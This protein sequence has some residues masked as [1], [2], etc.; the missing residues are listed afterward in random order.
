MSAYQ[1]AYTVLQK[2]LPHFPVSYFSV[3]MGLAGFTIVLQK[4][5]TFLN[6]PRGASLI[7]LGCATVLFVLMLVFYGMKIWQRF[8]FVRKELRHPVKLHFF[9]TISISLLLLSVAYLPLSNE[10][11]GYF[12]MTGVVLHSALMLFTLHAWMHWDIFKP[13]HM[14]PAWFIPAV[15]N[16]L[17]PIVGVVHAPVELSWF[18]F[19]VGFYF[20]IILSTIFFLRIFFHEPLTQKLLPTLCILIAPP[21]VGLIAYVQLIGR[22][23][24]FA[25]MLYNIALAMTILLLSQGY[26]FVRLP[27]YLSWW[28]YSFP[29]AAIGI[30]SVHMYH[31]T[32]TPMYKYLFIFFSVVLA[33]C[34][35]ILVLKTVSAIKKGTICVEE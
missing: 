5:E 22:V 12:W 35:A 27:F 24:V 26:L 30:A 2:R 34:I 8:D 32:T 31:A 18:Y 3:V 14:N 28:A 15:G 19:S 29:I 7:S 13:Q 20:W 21:S 33:G 25:S 23:D 9:P 16:I 4:A 6:A 11:S 10:I 1:R 17:V